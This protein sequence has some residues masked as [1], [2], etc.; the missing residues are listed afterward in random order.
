LTLFDD[1]WT[2]IDQTYPGF[3]NI[4]VDWDSLRNVYRPEI[5]AGVSRGRFAAIMNW[6]AFQLYDFHVQIRDNVVVFDSLNS[7]IPLFV[8]S[9]YHSTITK[10]IYGEKFCHFGANLAP[11]PDSSLFVYRVVPNHPLG[12][13]TGDI[14]LGYDKTPWKDLL[15]EIRNAEL[16]IWRSHVVGSNKSS[17]DYALLTS[18]GENWHLFD[19]IDILKF[20]TS[21]TLSLPTN[22]LQN[23]EMELINTDQLPI[24]GV[25]FP[26]TENGHWVSSGIVEGTNIGYIYVW[27]WLEA[28]DL[29]FHVAINTGDAFF[30]AVQT[31]KDEH[32]V[33]GLI[34]DS[35]YNWGGYALEVSK[36]LNV[37]FNKD[38]DIIMNF[39]R[40]DPENHLAL[41]RD[42]GVDHLFH[43]NANNTI[44]DRPVAVLTGPFS[45]SMGDIMPMEMRYHP[46]VKTFGRPTDGAFGTVDLA[47]FGTPAEW[48]SLIT[49][50]NIALFDRPEEYL[51]HKDIQPDEKVW[52]EQE[53]VVKGED[54][55]VKRAIDWITNKVYPHSAKTDTTF[56]TPGSTGTAYVQVKNPNDHELSVISYLYTMDDVLIDSFNMAIQDSSLYTSE[57]IL[58]DSIADYYF[59]F[60]TIDLEDG[61]TQLL[62]YVSR[63]T[64][65]IVSVKDLMSVLPKEYKLYQNYPN[66][67]NQITMI[68]YQLPI[69]SDV[70]LSIY[71]LLGQKVAT[72]VD[73]RQSTGNYSMEWNASDFASGVYYYRLRAENFNQIRKMVL[74]K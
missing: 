74:L 40:S 26:D 57:F 41:M 9:G 64:T 20:N 50:T 29:P 44:F 49:L 46:Y 35:R 11:M 66:P 42:T 60:K 16:P 18:A 52:F 24:S 38:Q 5:E 70:D 21:D 22:L 23:Q 19:T 53:D 51:M 68:N 14:I 69:K 56:Y 1:F 59:D 54:T 34:I 6:L 43:I 73:K 2:T 15:K 58:N 47:P 8:G 10:H 33:S 37:F 63:F 62:P 65:G 27:N 30:Q 12:L 45:I 4:N 25:P 39:E 7:G 48:F 3:H 36:A 31:L 67:F 55:V 71:N 28:G 61:D 13:E 72:L 32:N 17:T